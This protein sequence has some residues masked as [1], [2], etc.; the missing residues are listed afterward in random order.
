MNDLVAIVIEHRP[1]HHV[2]NVARDKPG[3]ALR[4][5][6]DK[7]RSMIFLLV[8]RGADAAID[9]GMGTILAKAPVAL[10]PARPLRIIDPRDLFPTHAFRLCL[11]R[12]GR[13]RLT[14]P[15]L[16][17]VTGKGHRLVQTLAR[18]PQ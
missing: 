3:L 4:D 13:K 14:W 16:K 6:L 18:L 8:Q 2:E 17:Q 15:R 10:L 9:A 5:I 1:D 12:R 7:D 11:C